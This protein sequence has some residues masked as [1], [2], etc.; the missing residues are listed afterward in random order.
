[1]YG[2]I[3]QLP[4]FASNMAWGP[5]NG[6][7][8][9]VVTLLRRCENPAPAEK[10]AVHEVSASLRPFNSVS[11][12]SILFVSLIFLRLPICIVFALYVSVLTSPC[13]LE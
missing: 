6:Y 1:M 2:Y 4:D 10:V 13:I 5:D 11:L 9:Q 8:Q 3:T 12:G 7:L